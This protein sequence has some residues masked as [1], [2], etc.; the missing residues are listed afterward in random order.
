MASASS[1]GL[2]PGILGQHHRGI[3]RHVAM[4]RIARRLDGHARLVDAGGQQARGD[5]LLI[6]AANAR[7]HFG[8]N[9]LCSHGMFCVDVPRA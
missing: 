2:Q 3:G 4:R 6:R 7:E 5:Q 1:R 8:K 9:V